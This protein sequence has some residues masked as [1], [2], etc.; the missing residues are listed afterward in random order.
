M[1]DKISATVYA[2]TDYTITLKATEHEALTDTTTVPTN[3]TV[4]PASKDIEQNN[5]AWAL[6]NES[7][8]YAAI[9]LEGAKYLNTK[10]GQDGVFTHTYPL[11]I[12]T[13]YNIPVGIYSTDITVTASNP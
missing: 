11:F 4:I 12:S 5:N 3:S 9:T 2:N 1:E 6:K 13:A 7:G 10:T 8:A